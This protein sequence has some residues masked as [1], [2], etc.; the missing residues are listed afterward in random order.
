MIEQELSYL[1]LMIY[2]FI[3]D[4]FIKMFYFNPEA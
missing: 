3:Q 1:N 2:L 4:I